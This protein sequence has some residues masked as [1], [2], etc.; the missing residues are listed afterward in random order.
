MAEDKKDTPEEQSPKSDDSGSTAV[1]PAPPGK[2]FGGR[3][4]EKKG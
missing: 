4:V 1:K 3:G 2:Q